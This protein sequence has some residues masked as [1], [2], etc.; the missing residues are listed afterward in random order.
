MFKF[1]EENENQNVTEMS[2]IFEKEGIDGVTSLYTM[3]EMDDVL[4][5]LSWK[6]RFIHHHEMK[7]ENG[8]GHRHNKF[9]RFFHHHERL[10]YELVIHK[11]KHHLKEAK[12]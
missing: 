3:Q 2:N 11:H 12:S 5:S 9:T 4:V 7:L 10:M 8:K 1:D 6:S